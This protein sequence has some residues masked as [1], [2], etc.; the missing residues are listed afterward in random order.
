M[1]E[2]YLDKL[3]NLDTIEKIENGTLSYEEEQEKI[4]IMIKKLMELDDLEKRAEEK[5]NE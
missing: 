3:A 4:M 5:Y 2:F 1:I